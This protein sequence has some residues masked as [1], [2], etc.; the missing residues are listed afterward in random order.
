MNPD[1]QEQSPRVVVIGAGH[2]GGSVVAFLRQYGFKGAITLIGNEPYLPYHRPP[3]SKAW[4]KGEVDGAALSLKPEAF[5]MEQSIDLRLG[6]RVEAIVASKH[7]VLLGNGARLP[8]DRLVIATGADARPLGLPGADADNVMTLRNIADAERLKHAIAP[9]K[10]VV[11]IGGGYV[12][13]ECAA[14]ARFLGADVLVLERAGRLL[15]RVAS[16]PIAS[17]LKQYHEGRGVAFELEAAVTGLEGN[18]CVEQVV[19]ADGRRIPCDV[20]LV[21]IGAVPAT[22]L[23][24]GAGLACD[25]GILVDEQCKTSE[26]DI[27][28]IGDAVRRNHP[29][30][31]PIRLESVPSVMEQA[32]LVA[33]AIVGREPPAPE[34]AW[35]WS[36][37]YDLKLQI[38]GLA[39]A[40]AKLVVRGDPMAGKFA[41][42]HLQ[43]GRV[44][45]VEAINSPQEFFAGKRMVGTDG[46]VDADRLADV[47]VPLNQIV[48]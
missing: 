8:Y 29:R 31:H 36:D 38:A 23:A 26:S 7:E 3:L 37:Q 12:G 11:I 5:Y 1:I 4:L 46:P 13:L 27:Y 10:K 2:G 21:G 42:F 20:V 43:D 48:A 28:A 24:I 15:E 40:G 41:V 25:D 44:K 6:Q 16:E 39:V 35:F 30:Y 17:F 22:A 14:T 32:K 9:G 47:S 19:L 45:T 18:G 34:V 33:C